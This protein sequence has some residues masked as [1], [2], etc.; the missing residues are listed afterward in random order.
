MSGITTH[1]LD[2]SIGRPA[3]EVP[4]TLAAADGAGGWDERVRVRTDADGRATLIG[5]GGPSAAGDFRLTFE[6]EDYLAERGGE[7]FYPRVDVHFTL[8][9]PDQHYHV[10]LLLSPY[11]YSTY[12]GS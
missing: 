10:P 5:S 9:H 3:P 6:V 1:I 7:P 8:A 4:V 12:R 2:I 11:G